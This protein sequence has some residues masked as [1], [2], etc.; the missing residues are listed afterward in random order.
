MTSKTWIGGDGNDAGDPANW[1]PS[2][3]PQPGD[4]LAMQG[5]TMN[6]RDDDLAGN[7]LVIGQ[8]NQ[9]ASPTTLNLSHHADVS[10]KTSP[11]SSDSV[12]INVD[13]SD[14]LDLAA[15][16][17]STTS[18][19]VNLADHARLA[20]SI[21]M[22]FGSAVFA[23]GSGSRY[24]NNG[25]DVV[26]GSNLT[27]DTDVKGQGSFA[28]STAQSSAGRLEFGGSVSRGQTVT[29]S[30]DPGR[31]QRSQLQIDQPA[32]FKG[33]VALNSFGEV[34]LV[35]LANADSYQLKND[36]LSI[37]SGCE[38]I[39]R[40]RLTLPPPASGTP[41]DLTVAQTATGILIDRGGYRGDGTLLPTHDGSGTG[42]A[43][44]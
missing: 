35:G 24:V 41:P 38:V 25:S 32:A 8:P 30:G 28:V 9:N 11:F 21:D 27:F 2:E 6:I 14:I 3:T 22:T 34:D 31:G 33:A 39:E 7:T 26:R 12:T 42:G 37:F 1:S 43:Q 20:G 17:P 29:V 23:G 40:L 13:G 44:F 15:G 16:F 4:T 18:F 5:G 36:I 19:T 10:V